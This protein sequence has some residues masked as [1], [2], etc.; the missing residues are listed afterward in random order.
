MLRRVP[1]LFAFVDVSQ[2]MGTLLFD[3]PLQRYNAHSWSGGIYRGERPEAILKTRGSDIV[4]ECLAFTTMHLVQRVADAQVRGYTILLISDGDRA[5]S[6]LAGLFATL[7]VD[8][9]IAGMTAD[10]E[11]VGFRAR[12]PQLGRTLNTYRAVAEIM[13]PDSREM[14]AGISNVEDDVLAFWSRSI[15]HALFLN[16]VPLEPPDSDALIALVRTIDETI[17]S[18][19]LYFLATTFG[20]SMYERFGI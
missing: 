5:A 2:R 15:D 14:R 3:A 17:D 20:D 4:A 11:R 16:A 8:R 9:V 7:L 13:Y 18:F 6:R 12:D 1:E 19:Y 10:E